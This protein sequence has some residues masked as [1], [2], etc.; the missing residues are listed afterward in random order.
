MLSQRYK[1][2]L[3]VQKIL[4]DKRLCGKLHQSLTPL[5]PFYLLVQ[6]S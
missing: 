1:R 5:I 4:R 6:G 2:L 3:K